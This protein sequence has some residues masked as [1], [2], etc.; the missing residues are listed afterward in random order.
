MR[1]FLA[2]A[3]LLAAFG[4]AC[5]PTPH[6]VASLPRDSVILV[7]APYLRF[8][9]LDPTLTPAMWSAVEQGSVGAVNSRARERGRNRIGSP[10]EG[11]LTI[12]SGVWTIPAAAAP[13]AYV[14]EEP[15]GATTAGAAFRTSTG[16]SLVS[17]RIGY[18]GLRQ[19]QAAN[20]ET[21]YRATVGV[22]GSAVASA[23]GVCAAVGNSDS[24]R[25]DS[26][27]G[28][29]RPAAIAAMDRAGRVTAG[30]VSP[31]LLMSDPSAP[32]GMRSDPMALKAAVASAT[33][34]MAVSNAPGL[35]VI[36]SGGLYRAALYRPQ[37]SA[38]DA[39][40]HRVDALRETDEVVALA[41]RMEPD[42]TVL[43]VGLSTADGTTTGPE[44]FAPIIVV[45]GDRSP[46]T[47]LTS[48]STHRTGLVNI[49]DV[50]ATILT[51]TGAPRPVEVLG[52][53][54]VGVRAPADAEDRIRMLSR[55]SAAAVAVDSTKGWLVNT[56]VA[57]TALVLLAS[58]VVLARSRR[59]TR[60]ATRGWVAALD[61]ALL[62]VGCAPLAGWLMFLVIRWPQTPTA[63]C[64]SF[65]GCLAAAWIGAVVLSRF[66]PSRVPLAV[67]ALTTALV[68]VVDQLVGAPLSFT[69]YFGYSPI[70]AA[71]F[72]G[73]GNEA[74]SILFGA[75]LVGLALLFDQWPDAR[76]TV[77]A[78]R[79][80]LPVVGAIVVVVSAAPFL[81]ANVGVAVWGIVG[82]GVAWVLMN[83]QRWSWKST[84]LLGLLVVATIGVFS[85]VDLL[86]GGSQ[87]HLGRA[88][89]SAGQGGLDELWTI[90]VRKAET[91]MRV[92]T[93]TN[94]AYILVAV[95][96]FLGF[97]RWRPQGEFAATL[98]EN[99]HF[100][101]AITVSLVAG[102]AAYFTEDSGIVIPAL[103][104]F[105]VGLALAWMML[106]RITDGAA[107]D[108][109]D[110]GGW[111]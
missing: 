10:V 52:N 32:F 88:L 49:L 25:L 59:M 98:K 85:L 76:R 110:G 92:L 57:L 3:A 36:D 40:R 93:A 73:M 86:G 47:Y 2:T 109:A 58:A 100:A 84:V 20:V 23:G 51:E 39:E 77:V 68:I 38:A 7:L 43:I 105:W 48:S 99:P 74:A 11:A 94:W 21:G 12:S 107:V 75:A 42:A 35:L 13:A 17:D 33:A 103:I 46:G 6:A 18:L 53:A 95:L 54:A 22:L 41:R 4:A 63:A 55:L 70:I 61:A 81:G 69:N 71:R 97:A 87:T 66:V 28:R 80:L 72:Y 60:S 67:V 27:S 15:Y 108:S 44:S 65:L 104:V 26:H 30:D 8:S 89:G 79:W 24:S 101:D 34:A 78:R 9:D 62:F 16:V 19:T 5:L 29:L 106:D 31:D 83:G 96:A 14:S 82:F 50:T 45:G 37:A 64:I 56:F 1:R 90:V 102:V 111:R 91:N